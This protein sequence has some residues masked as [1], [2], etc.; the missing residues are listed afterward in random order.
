M[1]SYAEMLRKGNT[2]YNGPIVKGKPEVLSQQENDFLAFSDFYQQGYTVQ[3]LL[4]PDEFNYLK[5]VFTGIIKKNIAQNGVNLPTD[6]ELENYH[7][8][9][10]SD[11]QHLANAKWYILV[12]QFRDCSQ[13][14]LDK[15]SNFLKHKLN[16]KELT[17]D[18]GSPKEILGYR[19]IRP[20]KNDSTPFHRDTWLDIWKGSFTVWVPIAGCNSNSTLAVLPGSHL[21]TEDVLCRS[22][23]NSVINGVKYKVPVLLSTEH[24][25]EIHYP[26]PAYGEALLF[27][28]Y[29]IHGGGENGN[30]DST[31]FSLEF[32]FQPA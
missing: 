25:F 30:I 32:R 2:P 12:D 14:V 11:A 3:P 1:Y 26:N 31:R 17:V 6:F 20:G 18:G 24:E 15:V 5:E 27:T 28:P 29:L 23:P 22:E 19:I 10:T 16:F 13:M 7:H 8:Y 21:W 4:S 9:V